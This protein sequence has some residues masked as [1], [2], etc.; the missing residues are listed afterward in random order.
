[1]RCIVRSKYSTAWGCSG[2]I[3][4]TVVW[5]ESLRTLECADVC[6]VD[7]SRSQDTLSPHNECTRWCKHQCCMLA[8][9]TIHYTK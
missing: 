9:T 2:L 7:A 5:L 3:T 8:R 4:T 6:I 1:M